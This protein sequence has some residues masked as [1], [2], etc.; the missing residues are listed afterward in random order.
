MRA[1]RREAARRIEKLSRLIH[2]HNHRY[3]VLDAPSIP[4]A[5]YDRLLRELQDLEA[6]HPDLVTV[7]TPTRRVGAEP[8]LAFAAVRHGIPMLSI[9][10]ALAGAEAREWDRR[11]RRSL[12]SDAVRYTVE[13]K[14]DGVSAS[15]RYERG[16]LVSAGTRGD[17]VTGEDVTANVRTINTVPLKLRRTNWPEVLEVRGE[18]V[19]PKKEFERLNREQLQRGAKIFANPRNAAAGSLRQLNPRATASRPLTFFP[20]GI[21]EASSLAAASYSEM[22]A[23][24]RDWGFRVSE[25]LR[26]VTGIDACLA[27]HS[28]MLAQRAA[29]PFEIDGVVYKV[30]DLSARERLGYTA[31]APRWAVA[32]KLP[33]QEEMTIVEDILASV[34]R[35][36]VITPVT[37]LRAVQ[38]GGAMVTHATLHNQDEV[39]RKDVRI[40]DTVIVRRAGDVIPEI[41]GIVADQRPAGTVPWRMPRH[42]PV[43]GSDVV[44]EEDAA[45]HRCSGGLYC[46]AQRTKAILHFAGRGAMDI[47]GL[48]EKLVQQLVDTGRVKTAADIF[49][50]TEQALVTLERMGEKS[51]SKLLEQI[52]RSRNVT[53]ARFLYALGIPQVGEATAEMLAGHFGSLEALMQAREEDLSKV[54]GVGL[55]MAGDIAVFFQ[56]AHNREVISGLLA[57]GV[58]PLPPVRRRDAAP[59]QGKVVVL[60]GSLSTMT[61]D[62]ARRRLKELGAKVTDSLSRSTD[63][64]IVGSDPGAKAGKAQALGIET[65]DEA[66]FEALVATSAP[67]HRVPSEES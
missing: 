36:G 9:D 53:L 1:D 49:A 27:Y 55:L 21:G 6:R 4:D 60:T 61:R 11:V 64:V 59:L 39:E 65:L 48:G 14:F 22:S 19:I 12:A 58:Q 25:Y 52:A 40:G 54:F 30:D 34:G 18:V 15:L 24:L 33:A 45:A 63:L 16:V 26:T 50:L 5:Q 28:E 44:R 13:P 38:V 29:L 2:E 32:H 46:P 23:L 66:G 17:G 31:R 42:C 67:D 62:E 8:L 10:N 43:C 56:Q 41:V 7:D 57:A 47:R 51:A 20:W 35:T 37:V 3:H